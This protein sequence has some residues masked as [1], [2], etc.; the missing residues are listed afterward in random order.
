MEEKLGEQKKSPQRQLRDIVKFTDV[1][2]VLQEGL[3]RDRQKERWKE[4]LQEIER[5]RTELLPQHQKMQK[6]FRISSTSRG[7]IASALA[8]VKKK[9]KGS[10][11]DGG[12][13]GAFRDTFPGSVGKVGRQSEGSSRVG[14]RNPDLAGR[15]EKKRQLCVVV[16]RMLL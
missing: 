12:T 15:G 16:R 3:L 9:C 1:G 2:P 10:V 14:R 11:R 6:G 8:L 13:E 5:K 4:G 7:I